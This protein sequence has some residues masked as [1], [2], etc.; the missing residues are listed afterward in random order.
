[1]PETHV[2]KDRL[3][4]VQDVKGTVSGSRHADTGTTNSLPKCC[5]LKR[6][7]GS[8]HVRYVRQATHT[9]DKSY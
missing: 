9:L 5:Y 1:M 2:E 4:A 7:D 8:G 6:Q 3:R